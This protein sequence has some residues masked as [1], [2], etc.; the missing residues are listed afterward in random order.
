MIHVGFPLYDS[1]GTYSKYEAVAIMS[2]LSSTSSELMVHIIHDHSVSDDI[3]CKLKEICDR[4]KQGC[5]FHLVQAEEF[6][7]L[8]PIAKSFTI[9]TLFRL[10]L[11]ELIEESISKIIYLD[12]DILVNTDIKPLWDENIHDYYVAACH[13]D[14]LGD[15][16]GYMSD[17]LVPA[18]KYYNAGVVVC[19]L[20]KIRQDFDLFAVSTEFLLSHSD[21]PYVDQDAANYFFMDNVLYLDA[22]YNMFTRNKRGKNLQLEDGIYHYA[23]DYV[24]LDAPEEFDKKY[25]EYMSLLHWDNNT[26]LDG[27]MWGY[28]DNAHRKINTLQCLC[29]WLS[30]RDNEIVLWGA[31]SKYLSKIYDIVN[32]SAVS[33]FVDNNKKIQG[34]KFHGRIIKS[35]EYIQG[36]DNIKVIVVSKDY[37]GEIKAQLESYG[38][39]ENIDFVDGLL[40]LLQSQGGR[41]KSY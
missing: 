26:G 28:V 14:G 16:N 34:K 20:Q 32:L 18:S 29:H 7:E 19:N 2:L 30:N 24:C 31:G 13:D 21:C 6:S 15:F 35:P 39:A 37:Y 5:V 23:G 3:K 40:L 1:R 9:G 11:P 27:F 33:F 41:V 10:K 8:A 22:K 4:F 12:A 38:F 25:I 17:G 36:K